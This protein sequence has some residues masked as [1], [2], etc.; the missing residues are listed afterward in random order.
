MRVNEVVRRG[1]APGKVRPG[2]DHRDTAQGLLSQEAHQH[3]GLAYFARRH[4][5][6]SVNV[7]DSLVD[8][9]EDGLARYIPDLTT[10]EMSSDNK[11]LGQSR[12]R[13]DANFWNDLDLFQTRG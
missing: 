1:I 3:R 8:Q 4:P 11:L 6:A 10:R 5:A 13:Q 9:L 2:P 7:H 12:S